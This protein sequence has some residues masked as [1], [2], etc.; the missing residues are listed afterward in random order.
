MENNHLRELK[1]RILRGTA[2]ELRQI[3]ASGDNPHFN[4]MLADRM[5]RRAD[6]IAAGEEDH[7]QIF[8][9]DLADDARDFLHG[10]QQCPRDS[11]SDG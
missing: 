4:N 10:D 6:R 2:D 9:D 3:A 5:L 11:N 1:V 8:P 7:S